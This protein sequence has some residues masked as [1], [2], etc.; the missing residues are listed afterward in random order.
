MEIF[1]NIFSEK[2][3]ILQ[4]FCPLYERSFSP[5]KKDLQKI[6]I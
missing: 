1:F 4:Y 5:L 6:H 2:P 3:H